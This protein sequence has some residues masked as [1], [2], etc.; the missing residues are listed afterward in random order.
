[1]LTSQAVQPST[2]LEV[3]MLIKIGSQF[4]LEVHFGGLYIR[5]GQFERFYERG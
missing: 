5:V 3:H 1:V 4:E 2:P